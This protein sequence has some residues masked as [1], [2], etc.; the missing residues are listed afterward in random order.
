MMQLEPEILELKQRLLLLE[1]SKPVS[2]LSELASVR[3]PLCGDSDNI[4]HAH[5]YIGVKEYDNE[6]LIVYD[7]KKCGRQGFVSPGFLRRLNIDDISIET[8]LKRSL[9]RVAHIKSYGK[10][11]DISKTRFLFPK[12]TKGDSKK[13]EYLSERLQMDFSNNEMIERYKVI[14]NLGSFLNVNKITNPA[15]SIDKIGLL[16]EYGV[17]FLSEDKRSVSIRN[18]DPGVS[19]KD[20]FNIIH[21]FQG[22]R[23]PFMYIPPCNLDVLSPYPHIAVSESPFNIICCKNYFF[24]EDDTSV[25]YA[26]AGRK[27]FSRPITRLIQLTGFVNG[28]IHIFADNDNNFNTD[29]YRFHLS[30]FLNNY[31]ITIY[32]NNAENDFGNMPKKGEK[33]NYKIIKL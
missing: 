18:M 14:L 7:C 9:K 13:I 26:A 28:Q 10:D 29:W 24:T 1:H 2:T 30:K 19:Y 12:I 5:L 23:H 21:L 20:R 27:L 8:Y 31:D 11:D 3:C 25:I 15:V 16:S 22:S 33:F 6:H 17:G 4:N 32:L